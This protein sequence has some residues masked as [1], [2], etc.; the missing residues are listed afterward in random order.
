MIPSIAGVVVIIVLVL[1]VVFLLRKKK[2]KEA[3]AEMQDAI[4]AA[5]SATKAL[6][7]ASLEE[8]IQAQMAQRALEQE[9]SDLAMLASV[10]L[11]PVKT[12]K[13]EVLAR[14][15]KENAK[16]DPSSSIQVLQSWLHDS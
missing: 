11:P 2:K 3:P 14:Q 4:A 16:K 8:Q 6:E 15:L 13:T 9:K 5:N 1:L 12:K 7:A 10:K